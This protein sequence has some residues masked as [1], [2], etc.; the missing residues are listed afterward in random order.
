MY[1][2]KTKGIA[3][4]FSFE[5]HTALTPEEIWVNYATVNNW[6]K[7]E[8]DLLAIS[9]EGDFKQGVSGE[10]TL[11]GM[12]PMAFELV[13]VTPNESFCDVTKILDLGSLYFNH[14]LIKTEKGTA[15]RH[16]VEFVSLDG[17]DHHGQLEF[18]TQVFSDVP[19]SIFS[20][21]E[22]SSTK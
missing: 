2:R 14:E 19:Q 16:T 8:D 13:E 12:P 5:T 21:I 6:F 3:M 1:L 9:L 10:M 15:V 11:Q 17:L 7:W 20:L 18:V 22:V 4:K